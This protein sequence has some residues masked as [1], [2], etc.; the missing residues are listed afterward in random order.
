[1]L[2]WRMMLMDRYVTPWLLGGDKKVLPQATAAMISSG[3]ILDFVD[4]ELKGGRVPW[5][6]VP[7]VIRSG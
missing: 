5:K 7:G 4:K 2:Q 3:R 6:Y 1:M